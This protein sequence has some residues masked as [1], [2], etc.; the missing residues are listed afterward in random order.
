M[1][2]SR[3]KID[4]QHITTRVFGKLVNWEQFTAARDGSPRLPLAARSVKE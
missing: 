1:V 2:T 4:G 3:W